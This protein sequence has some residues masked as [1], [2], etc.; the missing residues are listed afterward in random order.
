MNNTMIVGNIYKS[1]Y[2]FNVWDQ[3]LRS[4]LQ[5]TWS[6]I[7]NPNDMF[8]VSQCVAD[9]YGI[10]VQVLAC[11]ITGWLFVSHSDSLSKVFEAVNA[12]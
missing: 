8:L 4:S 9:G 11:G 2:M 12:S 7:L 6:G 1:K 10:H 5:R 3:K